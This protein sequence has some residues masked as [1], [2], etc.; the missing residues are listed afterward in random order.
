MHCA[1]LPTL[2][3]WFQVLKTLLFESNLPD[4]LME[5]DGTHEVTVEEH[6]ECVVT[7]RL[8]AN[9]CNKRQVLACFNSMQCDYIRE[10]S[11]FLCSEHV[12]QTFPLFYCINKVTD[13]IYS[14][15]N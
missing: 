13:F 6:L 9:D 1:T 7:C 12:V 11:P 5:W 3:W 14:L 15:G 8:T 10:I 2:S 4:L